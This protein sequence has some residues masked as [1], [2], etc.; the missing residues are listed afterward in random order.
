[1]TVVFSHA[2]LAISETDYTTDASLNTV[3]YLDVLAQ[4]GSGPNTM[5]WSI[6]TS[7]IG[8]SGWT[9]HGQISIPTELLGQDTAY[10]IDSG[11]YQSALGANIFLTG[12]TGLVGYDMSA[13]SA[14]TKTLIDNLSADQWITDSFD[15]AIR[16]ANGTVGWNTV[17]VV[18]GGAAARIEVTGGSVQEGVQ[19]DQ[20]GNLHDTESIL[21]RAASGDPTAFTV[22]PGCGQTLGNIIVNGDGAFTYTASEAAVLATHMGHGESRKDWF[23][24]KT[25]NGTTLDFY[26]T[27]C[28]N[29]HAPVVTATAAQS[30]IRPPQSVAVSIT[31]QDNDDNAQLSYVITGVPAGATLSSAG[32]PGGVVY[33]P[34]SQSWA[35]SA[36][37]L[38]DLMLTAGPGVTGQIHLVVTVTNTESNPASASDV[39]VAS[40]TATIDVT[41]DGNAVVRSGTTAVGGRFEAGTTQ[42]VEAGGIALNAFVGAA[43]TQDVFGNV[44]GTLLDH[45]TQTVEIGST[46]VGTIVS[47]GGFQDVRGTA[48]G[49]MVIGGGM[50]LVEQGGIAQTTFVADNAAE[51]VYGSANGTTVSAGGTQIV[52]SGGLA[53]STSVNLHGLQ[54][55]ESSG[56]ASSTGIGSGGTQTIRAGGT[57]SSTTIGNAAM[58]FVGGTAS[59]TTVASGG[60]EVVSAGGGANS[61][62]VGSGGVEIVSPGGVASGTIIGNGGSEVV[63]SAGASI[64]TVIQSGGTETLLGAETGAIVAGGMLL[65]SL[66]GIASGTIVGSGG[67]EVVSSGGLATG[68]TIGSSGAE[69][70]FAG[71]ASIGTFVQFGGIERVDGTETGAIVAGGVLG[72]NS[73]GVTNGVGVSS[74]GFE[75][76]S[77]GGIASGT[78]VGSGSFELI[79]SG[80]TSIDATIS[81][82]LLRIQAGGSA[83]GAIIFAG[84]GGIYEIDGTTVPANTVFGFA[85]GD[86]I[87]LAA[88]PGGAADSVS[89]GASNVLTI[90]D[91]SSQA[92]ALHLDPAQNFSGQSFVLRDD[93]HG[94]TSVH[95][96]SFPHV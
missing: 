8:A 58:Q 30:R 13:M 91:Q 42:T 1:M 43:G 92:Y 69:I 12:A 49:T 16:T 70:V 2:N 44:S 81:G 84:S 78:V 80:G 25:A 39:A 55:I 29:I 82:G 74:G 52:G 14:A 87:D 67:F 88:V 72:V 5:L 79:L 37:A 33:D 22:T 62:L 21:V 90:R 83:A 86:A 10:N 7:Q 38:A 96:G 17:T 28:G 57:A 64:G 94:G 32:N 89:L 48:S 73:G 60:T 40:A 34:A 53:T 15:Y 77:S 46:A 50:Q 26:E 95:L 4:A 71:G 24:V 45:G 31:A 68:T 35:V 11:T 3:Q 36:G 9:T 20:N 47:S 85:P 66:G 23:T 93:G 65:L 19:L 59:S 51:Y 6:G 54:V 18:I 41:V 27:V 63:L 56:I 75:V 76:V 61:T